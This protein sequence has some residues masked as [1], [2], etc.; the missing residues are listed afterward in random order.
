[1]SKIL[2]IKSS[3]KSRACL[4]NRLRFCRL[5]DGVTWCIPYVYFGRYIICIMTISTNIILV[6]LFGFVLVWMLVS[7][8]HRVY[9]SNVFE[10]I[11]YASCVY[12]FRTFVVASCILYVVCGLSHWYY[13]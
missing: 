13:S 1:M 11:R 9:I 6:L 8:S 7:V 3:N 2:L 4:E 10:S 12:V 5:N